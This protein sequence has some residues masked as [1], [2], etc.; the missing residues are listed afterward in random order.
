MAETT[1]QRRVKYISPRC[2]GRDV[3][4]EA[5]VQGFEQFIGD[6]IEQ[7]MSEFSISRALQNGVRG[8]GGA[9]VDQLLNNSRRLHRRVVEPELEMYRERTFEQ[10]SLVLDY[11][12]GDQDIEAFRED[13]LTTGAFENEIRDDLSEE[14][15][16]EVHDYLVAR[17]ERLGDAVEPLVESPEDEFWAAATDTLTA[18]EARSLVEKH[19]AY[20]QP[21]REYPE[22]FRLSTTVNTTDVLGVFGSLLGGTKIEVEYTDEALRALSLA[23]ESVIESAKEDIETRFGE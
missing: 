5:V 6:A 1:T 4:R 21:L 19:F 11:A 7:S 2:N 22:V 16:Q 8:P 17:Y 15:R 18:D 10:F 12:E 20:T 14:R 23:E 3:T 9:A 13:L